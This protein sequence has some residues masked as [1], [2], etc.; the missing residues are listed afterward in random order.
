LERGQT[1]SQVE[2][3][4]VDDYCS[5]HGIDRIDILKSDTEGFDL[6]VLKGASPLFAQH[7]IHLVY[8]EIIFGKHYKNQGRLDEIYGFL[9]EGGFELVSFYKNYYRNGLAKWT[10]APFVDAQYNASTHRHAK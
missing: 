8:L 6:E 4:T 1:A 10:D 2:I 7:R 9:A 5:Q 3:T